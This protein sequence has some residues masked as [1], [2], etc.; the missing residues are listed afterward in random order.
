MGSDLKSIEDIKAIRKIMEESSRFL[1]LSGLSG[2]FI[3]IT[4]IIGALIAYFLIPDGSI[5]YGE[6]FR[7]HSPEE[8]YSLRWQLFAD[9]ALVLLLSIF[10]AFWFS[11]RKAKK[12]GK[13]FMTPISKRLL[14]NLIIPLATGGV[15]AIVL[16]IQNQIELIVPCFLIFYGLSLVNAGKFTFG[17]IFYLGMLEIITGLVAAFFPGW[18]LIFWIFGFGI[19]H[20]IYGLAMYRKYEA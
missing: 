7:N 3:G 2:V 10:L 15:F 16:L 6:Y 17:E 14:I 1:S 4:A 20:I 13:I 5:H 18:G 8:T 19:L 9:A 11:I 12:E